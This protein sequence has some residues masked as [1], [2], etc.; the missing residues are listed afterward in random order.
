MKLK[1]K[2]AF[3]WGLL[4]F[5]LFC[6]NEAKRLKFKFKSSR[7]KVKLN[8]QGSKSNPGSSYPSSNSY[9]S[10]YSTNIF[11]YKDTYNS[12]FAK[13]VNYYRSS[14]NTLAY[15]K[16]LEMPDLESTLT[17]QIIITKNI[18]IQVVLIF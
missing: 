16:H 10:L 11:H 1:V 4:I 5:G 17:Y 13:P 6:E 12:H 14:K 15:G 7:P 9:H 8:N 18:E 3:L 2:I